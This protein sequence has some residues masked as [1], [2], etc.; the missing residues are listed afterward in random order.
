MLKIQFF[1]DPNNGTIYTQNDVDV[2]LK[3]YNLKTDEYTY[4]PLSNHQN[5]YNQQCWVVDDYSNAYKIYQKEKLSLLFLLLFHN[6]LS[7]IPICIQQFRL[8]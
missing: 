2:Y 5:I 3:K 6:L 8:V 4:L 7:P 1:I